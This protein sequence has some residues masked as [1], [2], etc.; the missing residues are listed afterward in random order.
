MAQLQSTSITGSLIVTGGITGSFSGSIVSPGSNTQVLFNNSGVI[1]ANS[2]FVYSSGNVG[3][4][5]TAPTEK[6]EVVGNAILTISD[7]RFRGGDTAG[8]LVVSNSN[9]TSYITL[10]GSTRAVG[11]N[12]IAFVANSTSAMLI[13]STGNVGIG[14]TSPGAKLDIEGNN[15]PLASGQKVLELTDNIAWATIGSGPKIVFKRK[16]LD[17]DLASIRSYVFGTNLTGLAFDTGHNALTTKMVIDNAGNVGIGTTSPGA[18]LE[19]QDTANSS[20]LLI[21]ADGANEQL[22][23]R[24]YSNT[25]EQLIFGFAS[26]DYGYV[27]AVEQ[28]VAYRAFAINPNGGNVGIGTSSPVANLHLRSTSSASVMKITNSS[29]GVGVLDGIDIALGN[30]FSQLWYYENG[31]FR[32]ATNNTERMRITN[33]GNVG[34]GTTAPQK[35]LEVI[36]NANDFVSVGVNQIGIGQWTGIHFGYRENNTNYRKSAI[37]FERT[38]LTS[39]NAQGKVHILNGPQSG[40]NSATL[41]DAK[42]TIAEN[43]YTGIGTTSPS[44]TLDVRSYAPAGGVSS[45]TFKAFAYDTDSCF[46]VNNNGNN[47]ANITLYR[48]DSATMFSV[49]GHSGTTYFAGSVGIAT[50]STPGNRLIVAQDAAYTNENTY[51][52]AAAAS[53]NTAYKTIIGYD[54]SNDIGVISAVAAG[55]TWKNL[56]LAPVGGN[57]GIGTITPSQKLDVR[58]TLASVG[59]SIT[60]AVSYADAAVFGSFSNHDTAFYTNSSEKMRITTAGNVGIGTSTP[61][62]LLHLSSTA[63]IMSFT[64]TN[65]FTDP[66][67]RFIIRAGANQGNVQWYDDSAATTLDI[68]TFLPSG[69]VGIGTTSPS[70]KLHVNGRTLVDQF[71]YTKAINYSSGDL[72]SLITA[73]FYNGSG[74]SNAPNSGWFWVTVETFSG[75]TN[76]IHQ[77]AT[78]FG[79]LNTANEVYTRVRSGGSWGAWKQLGDAGSVSGTTNYVAKFTSGTAIGNSQIFDNGTN[80]GIGTAVPDNRLTI[81]GGISGTPSWNNATLELRADS[82]ITAAIAFHRAGYTTSHIY[83]DDGSIAT[84]IGST[85]VLR[86]ATNFNVGIGTTNPGAKLEVNGSFRATTKSF[87]I[88][89]PTKEGK[90]LQYGVLEGPEHSVYVRGKLT[91]TSRIELPDY[92]HALV[93]ENSITVNLTAIGRKQELWVEE[94]TDTYIT[95]GSEAGIINCFYTVFAERKDVEKLVTEFDKE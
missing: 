73:G 2:G 62:S 12:E 26:S 3:I 88:D 94:I 11:A 85:E 93:D 77:T 81:N 70:Q 51:N 61:Q 65:S 45:P 76:W 34:I 49:D 83:S 30:G 59:N 71:Q 40:P 54:Y 8:R 42:L 17:F 37:V 63:P 7:S 35:P 84:S 68:M 44:A 55:I 87:I 1:S 13:T 89:H 9:T 78:S 92:W 47:S 20:T 48:S 31:Y 33:A 38:D 95:V 14:T 32:I 22:K 18:K 28:G 50:T 52:I 23:I 29:S 79:S 56:S 10:N 15:S 19:L 46:E 69:N 57:V 80:V 5:T 67:D 6:L 36:S 25:N 91:N 16:D 41:S 60:A 39:N 43:G 74:M 27:Q 66:L 21:T 75:D 53:T 64:D 4:G 86:V 72:N 24:R 82:G 58:G 90:K